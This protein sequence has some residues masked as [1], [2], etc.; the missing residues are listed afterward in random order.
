M[1]TA[2]L[3]AFGVV[4][5]VGFAV[6]WLVSNGFPKGAR[7]V[8][9]AGEK[10]VGASADA[11]GRLIEGLRRAFHMEPTVTITN[12]V[13]VIETRQVA[14]LVLLEQSVE[15][16]TCYSNKSSIGS[17]KVCV[18]KQHHTVAVGYDLR[19][20]ARIQVDEAK[21]TILIEAPTPDILY[22]ASDE[23]ETIFRSDG[24]FN[25]L[26]ELD[27]TEVRKQLTIALHESP[28]Y[29]AI[30][31]SK[32]ELLRSRFTDLLTLSSYKVEIL[33]SGSAVRSNKP[34]S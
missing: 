23:P 16:F 10:L 20:T 29:K 4:L 31:G 6:G 34:E 32:F 24:V 33:E 3:V 14:K 25:K 28:Q 15:T 27:E 22:V 13:A 1:T 7:A 2:I 21:R 11:P 8:G 5:V 9:D 12:Q 19:A 30:L 17:E 26:S 18:K